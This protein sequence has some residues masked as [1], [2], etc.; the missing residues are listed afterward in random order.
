M[1]GFYKNIVAD[2]CVT[3]CFKAYYNQ[4]CFLM[5]FEGLLFNFKIS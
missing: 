5:I 4:P 2:F 1:L 3:A